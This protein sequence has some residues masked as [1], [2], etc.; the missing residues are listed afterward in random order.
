MGALLMGG[1]LA[2][3]SIWY[4]PRCQFGNDSGQAGLW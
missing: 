4:G 1:L 2:Y 3:V